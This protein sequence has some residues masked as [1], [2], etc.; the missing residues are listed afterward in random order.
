MHHSVMHSHERK[1]SQVG[2]QVLFEKTFLNTLPDQPLIN[3]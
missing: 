1:P 2:I 3:S